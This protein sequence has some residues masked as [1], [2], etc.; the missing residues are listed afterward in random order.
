MKKLHS[1][2]LLLLILSA[3]YT[4]NSQIQSMNEISITPPSYQDANSEN[5]IDFLKNTIV[6]PSSELDK[7]HQGT[8]VIQFIVSEYGTIENVEV[9]NSVSKEMDAEVIRALKETSGKWEPGTID[10]QKR[11]MEKEIAISFVIYSLNDMLRTADNYMQKG[12]RLLYKKDN[13]EKALLY[14]N[15][16][17]TLFPYAPGVL[18]MKAYCL[19]KLGSKEEAGEIRDRID[20]LAKRN[21]SILMPFDENYLSLFEPLL[22]SRTEFQ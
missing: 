9:I 14:Y 5:L 10:S 17:C 16:A 8:E 22:L 11:S 12:N 1:L 20:R 19:Q 2:G 15:K 13:T 4:A 18:S 7:R 6:Y 3:S 21:T